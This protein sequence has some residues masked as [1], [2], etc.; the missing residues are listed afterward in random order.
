MPTLYLG[1]ATT[2]PSLFLGTATANSCSS[3]ATV[4]PR[5]IWSIASSIIATTCPCLCL[6]QT[7]RQLP[8]VTHNAYNAIYRID[9]GQLII[10]QLSMSLF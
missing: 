4:Q 2:V 10:N 7:S 3:S 5:Y 9:F 1:T 6:D 8:L